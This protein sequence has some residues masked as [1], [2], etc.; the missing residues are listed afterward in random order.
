MAAIRPPAAAAR[1]R[2][3]L[4]H[5]D[6]ELVAALT[7]FAHGMERFLAGGAT[8]PRLPVACT[9][10][11]AQFRDSARRTRTRIAAVQ[12]TLKARGLLLDAFDDLIAALTR[13]E[14]ILSAPRR[15]QHPA[16]FL[17]A[18]RAIDTSRRRIWAVQRSLR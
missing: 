14:Q 6:P 8:Q 18:V 11:S 13:A 5:P 9:R 2:A 4:E 7:A 3:I 12:T 16:M 15:E 17:A 10:A 1:L